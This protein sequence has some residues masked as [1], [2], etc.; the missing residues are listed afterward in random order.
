MYGGGP[1]YMFEAAPLLLALA[2]GLVSIAPRELGGRAAGQGRARAVLAL[3]FLLGFAY[4]G[5]KVVIRDAHVVKATT[6]VDERMFDVV[7]KQARPPALVFLPVP[8][9]LPY[10]CKFY[11]AIAQ[12]DPLLRGPIVYARDLGPKNHLLAAARPG[13]HHYR[14]N[15][16]TFR[17]V[18]IAID[19]SPAPL[20]HEEP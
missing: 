7:R 15:H 10:T 20:H 12:N 18:P 4:A 8:K 14:W 9:G 19:G 16:E 5:F 1:R 2:A 6:N 11:A 17:P 3:V 13:R